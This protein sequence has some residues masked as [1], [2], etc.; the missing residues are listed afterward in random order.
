MRAAASSSTWP[1]PT[2]TRATGSGRLKLTTPAWP[3]A[4][5]A[6]S[7]RLR[8][9]GIPVAL[10]MAGGYGHDIDDTVEVQLSTFRA[11]VASFVHGSVGRTPDR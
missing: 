2:R 8:E 7:T 11:A 9:R 4:T 3:S 10:A 1:A 6:C 5:G